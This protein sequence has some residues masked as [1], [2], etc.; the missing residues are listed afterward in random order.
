MTQLAEMNQL[1]ENQGMGLVQ[2]DSCSARAIYEVILPYGDLA[3]CRHH[4]NKNAVALTNQGGIAK[5]LSIDTEQVVIS[6]PNYLGGGQDFVVARNNRGGGGMGGLASLGRWA[7]Q[8]ATQKFLISHRADE[9]I[10]VQEKGNESRAKWGAVGN[11]ANGHFLRQETLDSHDDYTRRFDDNHPDVVSGKVKKIK[12]ENGNE[13]Y[14]YLR[15]EL[16]RQYIEGGLHE[17]KRG[18]MSIGPVSQIRNSQQVTDRERELWRTKTDGGTKTKETKPPKPTFQPGPITK[19]EGGNPLLTQ[20]KDGEFQG[21]TPRKTGAGGYD[22]ALKSGAIDKDTYDS[23]ME[24]GQKPGKD[25][26]PKQASHSIDAL[27]KSRTDN[28]NDGNEDGKK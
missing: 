23:Y 25:Y 6:M 8:V 11:A 20:P 22:E 1:V 2:C 21:Y 5:I 4:Y 17:A 10:R 19:G 13:E 3:F 12:D 7:G 16:A 26:M 24:D 15:P 18:G 28:L 14:P 27:V 9:Q